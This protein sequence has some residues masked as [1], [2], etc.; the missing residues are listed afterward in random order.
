[1]FQHNVAQWQKAPH[2][3]EASLLKAND[4]S[5]YFMALSTHGTIGSPAQDK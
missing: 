4:P 2:D 1:M 5:T 3:C